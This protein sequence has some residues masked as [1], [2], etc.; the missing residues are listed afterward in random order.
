M[1]LMKKILTII[2]L[3]LCLINYSK[4]ADIKD[5]KIEGMTVGDSLLDYFSESEIKAKLFSDYPAS[6]RFKRFYAFDLD[7]FETYKGVQVN[8]IK[9]DKKY[10]IHVIAGQIDFPNN[11]KACLKEQRNVVKELDTLFPTAKK[12]KNKAK[13]KWDKKGKSTSEYVAYLYEE[14][15]KEW[16]IG[17]TCDD[18]SKEITKKDGMQDN[19][20][21][22]IRSPEF[23]QFLKNEAY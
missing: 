21:V 9:N 13:K 19:L 3:S 6:D 7:W 12:I 11:I 8:F 16:Q 20:S 10:I 2:I 14:N 5:F 22:S 18:W 17:V 1:C 4:A 23:V 15:E